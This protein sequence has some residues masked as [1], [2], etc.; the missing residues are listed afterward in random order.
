MHITRSKRP[1]PKV[2]GV[3]QDRSLRRGEVHGP[4]G[5]EGRGAGELAA[6]AASPGL[7]RALLNPRIE[8]LRDLK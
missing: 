1:F 4:G 6:G 2:F 8:I 3:L 7:R 5:G